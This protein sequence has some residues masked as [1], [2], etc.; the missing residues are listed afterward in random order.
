MYFL[1]LVPTFPPHYIVVEKGLLLPANNSHLKVALFWQQENEAR[2]KNRPAT[3]ISGI[4]SL[5][6]VVTL[7]WI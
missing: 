3:H 5:L 2:E 7:H 4:I 6:L 1:H